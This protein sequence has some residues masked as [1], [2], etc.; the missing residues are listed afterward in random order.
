M[1]QRVELEAEVDKGS[2]VLHGD[3]LALDDASHLKV[4]DVAL[5]I[6][7]PVGQHE[8]VGLRVRLQE[9]G[10]QGRPDVLLC[11]L[12]V[13][14]EVGLWNEALEVL[15]LHQGPAPAHVLDPHL[16]DGVLLVELHHPLPRHRALDEPG[17]H[18]ES[19]AVPPGRDDLELPLHPG[20]DEGPDVGGV[21]DGQLVR[22]AEGRQL[23]AD[24]DGAAPLADGQDQA[25]DPVTWLE[26]VR[27]RVQEALELLPLLLEVVLRDELRKVGLHLEVVKVPIPV[28][29]RPEGAVDAL[30]HGGA[31]LLARGRG[32]LRGGLA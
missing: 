13:H 19:L 32:L 8:P 22:G 26:P 18:E 15:Q 23:R 20:L 7:E 10:D 14:P 11:L 31:H 3:N 6:R 27:V 24:L 17:R 2:V 21:L 12:Q 4:L 5:H 16:H 1:Q 29:D 28:L 30:E 9:L 25:H